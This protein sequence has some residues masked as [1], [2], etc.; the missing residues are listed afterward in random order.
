MKKSSE[1]N[2]PWALFL[3]SGRIKIVPCKNFNEN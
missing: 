1:Y 2:A 3:V